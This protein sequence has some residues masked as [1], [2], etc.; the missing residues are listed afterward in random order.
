MAGKTAMSS[1][2]TCGELIS[3]EF[4]LDFQLA[5]ADVLDHSL[6]IGRHFYWGCDVCAAALTA[7]Q[8]AQRP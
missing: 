1:E 2:Q 7:R 3:R 6:R 5:V 8:E 4:V